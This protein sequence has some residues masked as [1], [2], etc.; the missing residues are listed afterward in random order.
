MQVAQVGTSFDGNAH[1]RAIEKIHGMPMDMLKDTISNVVASAREHG[2][3][4]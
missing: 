4:E 2:V 3:I 1:S